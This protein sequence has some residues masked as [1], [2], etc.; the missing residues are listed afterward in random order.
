[1]DATRATGVIT[2]DLF[3]SSLASSRL[4]SESALDKF[5]LE[6]PEADGIALAH[7]LIQ[8]GQLT[9]YQVDAISQGRGNELYM[10]NYDVLDRLGAGGMGTVLKARHR[11]MKR[12]VALKVLSQALCQDDSFVQRF[13]REVETI[14]LLK[15]PN[16]VMAYDADECEFGHFLV[17]EFVDG[18]DLS[19]IVAK[20][21]PLDVSHSIDYT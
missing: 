18:R 21:G 10:G 3:L 1:M 12:I 16:I 13:Q 17:M 19:S 7:A 20:I 8:S 11:R 5:R 14:A 4:L 9:A 6:H 15:H 2:R